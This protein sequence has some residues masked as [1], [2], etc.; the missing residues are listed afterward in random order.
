MTRQTHR[1]SETRRVYFLILWY[2][3]AVEPSWDA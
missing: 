1:G 3:I 2:N